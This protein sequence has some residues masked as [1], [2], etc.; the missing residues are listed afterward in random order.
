MH[1]KKYI[2][3]FTTILLSIGS[4]VITIAQSNYQFTRYTQEEGLISSSVTEIVKDKTGFLWLM[5]ENGLMRFDGYE[6]KIFKPNADSPGSIPAS[7]FYE[8]KEDEY[9]NILIRTVQSLCKYFPA[10]GSFKKIISYSDSIHIYDWVDGDHAEF[11]AT[12]PYHLL[13]IDAMTETYTKYDLPAT[14]DKT[15]IRLLTDKKKNVWLFNQKNQLLCFNIKEKKFSF[16]SIRNLDADGSIL[17]SNPKTFFYNSSGTTCML[18]QDGM[19]RYDDAAKTFIQYTR[20]SLNDTEKKNFQ[21]NA[22]IAGNY[23]FRGS[24]NR[25]L[26]RMDTNDGSQKMYHLAKN[27]STTGE[28]DF[29]FSGLYISDDG[30]VWITTNTAGAFHFFPSTETWEQFTSDPSNQNSL[31]SN[32][33]DLIYEDKNNVIW[34]NCSGRGIV[35]AEPLKPFLASYNPSVSKKSLQGTLAENVRTIASFDKAQ[36]LIGTLHGLFQFNIATHEFEQAISPV[37]NQPVLTT[38]AISNI[39]SDSTG[40]FWISEWGLPG[41]HLINYKAGICSRMVPDSTKAKWFLTMRVLFI[42][43]HGFLWA[44]TDGNIIYRAN[45][46]LLD[47]VHPEKLNFEIY[48]GTATK[49]DTLNFSKC[50]SIAENADRNIYFATEG[51]LYE[52]NYATGKFK[53]YINHPGDPE[54]LSDN[55]VRA[56]CIDRS[57][58]LWLGTVNGGLNRLDKTTNTFSHFTMENG[59]PD[60][61]VYSVLE[62]NKGFLW[63]GTNKGLCRFNPQNKSCRNYS[64]KDGIQNYEFNTNAAYKTAT[65]EL[66]FGGRTGF[67]FYNPDSIE[68]FSDKP[69]VVITRLNIFDKEMQPDTNELKLKYD[70]NSLSFQFAALSFFR[71]KENQYAYKL[72][73]LENHWIYCGDRRFTNY[74]SLPPGNYTFRVKASNCYGVWNETGASLKLFIDTPWWK[75]WWFRILVAVILA[76]VIFVLFRFRLEQKLKLQAVRNRIARDLHDEI[77]S[78]LSS[79]ILFS[80]VAKQKSESESSVFPLLKKISDYTQTSQEA[81]NDIVWMINSKND[82]FENMIVRMR[83]IAAEMFEAKQINFRLNIDEKLNYVK[84]G[85]DERKNFYL[86]YKEAINN[87]VKY[88]ECKNVSVDLIY[89]HSLL[90]LSIK[91]DGKGFDIQNRAKGNG[92]SNMKKRSE[93]LNGK[94]NLISEQGKG[95]VIELKFGI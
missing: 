44:G 28:P 37:D 69:E 82:R 3:L 53:R 5:S 2:K 71:N 21:G 45:L 42:D 9:G 51:G 7:G 74:A 48:P 13:C 22:V 38:T 50:F 72:E 32:S 1:Q 43:S 27:G 35:K 55:N 16:I 94:F 39:I 62:D 17:K 20:N 11:W 64:L 90:I 14:F 83:T 40:N 67:N 23:L 26:I 4:A 65:G 87:I 93:L 36:L 89:R 68:I 52:F 25:N 30:S 78:N 59:L 63:L 15:V 58:T 73:G 8:M 24:S 88:A 79:I 91:D 84:M 34:F 61:A 12:S 66:A 31:L 60:N 70:E 80:E 81:I 95:T 92:L 85:M 29:V 6:F 47:P 54:S 57:G 86:I 33:V 49:K 76:A 10:S 18:T 41:I 75:T 19:F 46:N 56:L 77:G